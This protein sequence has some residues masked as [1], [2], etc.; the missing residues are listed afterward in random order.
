MFQRGDKDI[1]VFDGA[2][3]GAFPEDYEIE[4]Q[5][6]ADGVSYLFSCA[7][8]RKP[9]RVTVSHEE[10]T[11]VSLGVVPKDWSRDDRTLRYVPDLS[12]LRCG[13]P[14]KLGISEEEAVRLAKEAR[15][16]GWIDPAE[17]LNAVAGKDRGSA[18][19]GPVEAMS[20]EAKLYDSLMDVIE[21]AREE[22]GGHLPQDLESELVGMADLVWQRMTPAEQQ[23][24][25]DAAIAK[26]TEKVE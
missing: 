11:A 23:E 6:A 24:R 14:T 2:D 8:C 22:N 17:A 13:F 26:A 9:M 4:A 18:E 15:A 25:E 3:S 10:M 16:R 1:S 12:C 20:S 7:G 21:S 19:R 5:P